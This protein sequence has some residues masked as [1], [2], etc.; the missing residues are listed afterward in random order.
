MNGESSNGVPPDSAPP[1]SAPPAQTLSINT[2][3]IG[4]NSPLS[5][6]GDLRIKDQPDSR[7]AALCR[8]GQSGNK[9]FCDATHRKTGFV[10]SGEPAMVGSQPLAQR[11]GP[12]AIVPL[13]NGPLH[14]KGNLEIVSALGSTINR[15]TETWLCRCGHS[16]N[17]PYCDGTHKKQ[18]F[19]AP[20]T[21][22]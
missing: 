20:G 5:F 16:S 14:V 12:L 18:G 9:P 19:L 21:P 7:R 10:A 3:Q 15:V 17:K 4:E 22:R 1:D 11:G 8:C 6:R 2:V 13:L